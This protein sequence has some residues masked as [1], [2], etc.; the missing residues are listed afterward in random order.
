M[1]GDQNQKEWNKIEPGLWRPE[2]DG[3]EITGI[4]V[5]IEDSTKYE[6]KNY[7]IEVKKDEKTEQITIFGTTV[8]DNKMQYA[9]IGQ[10]VR[11]VYKGMQKNQRGQDTKIFEVY[12]R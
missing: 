12:T 2:K 9:K 5:G 3:E 7:C 11:I 6:N 8:L 4:L 1:E 10:E